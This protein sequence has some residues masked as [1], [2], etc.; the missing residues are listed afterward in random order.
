MVKQDR[1]STRLKGFDYTSPSAYF[2][3]IVTKDRQCLFG[4]VVD[5]E[6]HLNIIG[7]LARI[8]WEKI[9]E[10]FTHITIDEFAIM[11]NHVHGIMIINETVGVRQERVDKQRGS[12]F[13][14]P[15]QACGVVP[16]SL[17]AAIGYFKSGV[18]RRI[19]ALRRTPSATAWQRSYY[20][21]II[22]NED[23]L[24][25]TR[26]YIMNNPL[27]LEFDTENPHA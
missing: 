10:H 9:P 12:F 5:G 11:P 8:V 19:N 15:V 21:R 20:D 14:S 17:G 7:Q 23:E 13:A 24:T 2:V 3:T 25:H 6:M 4:D 26:Q 1:K 27:K 18:T 22:R 16:G